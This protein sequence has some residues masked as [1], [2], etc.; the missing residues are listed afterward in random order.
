[1]ALDVLLASGWSQGSSRKALLA[2]GCVSVVSLAW[3]QLSGPMP[4]LVDAGRLGSAESGPTGPTVVSTLQS[5][6]AV[7]SPMQSVAALLLGMCLYPALCSVYTCI[8]AWWLLPGSRRTSPAFSSH[9]I[10]LDGANLWA[11]ERQPG[12]LLR[13][14]RRLLAQGK[15]LCSDRAGELS[16]LQPLHRKRSCGSRS[17]KSEDMLSSRLSADSVGRRSGSHSGSGGGGGFRRALRGM[18]GRWQPSMTRIT[19]G[20]HLPGLA[21]S[22]SSYSSAM[23]NKRLELLAYNGFQAVDCLAHEHTSPEYASVREVVTDAH[24]LQ[25]GAMIGEASAELALSQSNC[26]GAVG[27]APVSLFGPYDRGDAYRQGWELVVEDHKP[28][29]HYWTWRRHLRK[30]LYMYKSK[31]VYEAAT[32]AQITAF[33][34]DL[35]FRKTWD[36]AAAAQLAIAPPDAASLSAPNAAQ[37]A[38]NGRSAFMYARSKFP[39]PMASREYLFARRCWRKPDDGGCY[40]ISRSCVHP[41]PPTAP[42]RT[43]MVDDF[44]SGYVIRS[45]KGV[46]DTASPATEV[47]SVYFEDSHVPSGIA[48]MGIRR[49]LWPMVQKAEAAFRSYLVLRVHASIPEQQPQA[50]GASSADAGVVRAAAAAAAAADAASCDMPLAKRYN[51]YEL[52]YRGYMTAWRSGASGAQATLACSVATCRAAARAARCSAALLAKVWL[53]LAALTLAPSRWLAAMTRRAGSAA[54]AAMH[55]HGAS[56][57]CS[58]KSGLPWPSALARTLL[59]SPASGA[60]LRR[61][62]S[63]SSPMCSSSP[64][65]SSSA[66]HVR[67]ASHPVVTVVARVRVCSTDGSASGSQEGSEASSRRGR[68]LLRRLGQVAVKAAKVAG[69]S[70]LLG[71]A[72][73]NGSEG[74]GAARPACMR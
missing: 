3:R 53:A 28:G 56:G 38:D 12:A 48:N 10:D 60:G 50:Q 5:L 14:L 54:A 24:L 29:L 25:F 34:Y 40:C 70:V 8:A 47:I 15:Q 33:T 21:A 45:S 72:A 35:E 57:G 20:Q 43:L 68:G 73:R 67:L 63:G 49:A 9:R 39:P 1:M 74:G 23:S 4:M 19:S 18:G 32:T 46:Y 37:A 55:R 13:R 64:S 41:S 6:F 11:S 58:S 2:G 71:R 30:G 52:L 51:M 59:A 16:R 66:G 42:G 61:L 44:A 31:T 36:E 27:P 7:G 65:L 22:V 62:P 69:A 17:A 26:S